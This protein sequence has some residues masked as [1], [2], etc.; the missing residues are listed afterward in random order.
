MAKI[1]I[2]GTSISGFDNSI[3]ALNIYSLS[4][5]FLNTN[6]PNLLFPTNRGIISIN[7]VGSDGPEAQYNGLE[8]LV[9]NDGVSGYGAK[10]FTNDVQKLFGLAIR[11]NNNSWSNSWTMNVTTS[12]AIFYGSLSANV[13][14]AGNFQT[15]TASL[16]SGTASN[17]NKITSLEGSTAGLASGTASNLIQINTLN[18]VQSHY[19]VLSATNIFTNSN[20]IS[21]ESISS[22]QIYIKN[23]NFILNSVNNSISSNTISAEN[24]ASLNNS[25]I[26]YNSNNFSTTQLDVSE[27]EFKN[28]DVSIWYQ[29]IITFFN[30][31]PG[32]KNLNVSWMHKYTTGFGDPTPPT[33]SGTLYSV[34]A[35]TMIALRNFNTNIMNSTFINSSTS[36]GIQNIVNT[37]DATNR[38]CFIMKILGGTDDNTNPMTG[39]VKRITIEVKSV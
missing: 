12:A 20:S 19:A 33:V 11:S 25:R 31:L 36:I 3:T 5:I 27:L 38:L 18:G 32:D 13:L 2:T 30:L 26:V 34:S 28:N 21:G 7:H 15:S 35:D 8:F 37:S 23:P 4:S 14:L 6:K 1:V 17:L 10:F 39:H 22:G 16:A 29:P 9:S 24:I